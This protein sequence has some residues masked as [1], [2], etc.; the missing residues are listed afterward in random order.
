MRW[1]WLL[2]FSPLW[3]EPTSVESEA[4]HYDG[5]TIT[6][7]GHVHVQNE[8]GELF[9]EKAILTKDEE[10]RT[11]VDFPWIELVHSVH[12]LLKKGQQLDCSRAWL[13]YT[14]KTSLI[15]GDPQLHF[16]DEHGEVF[17]NSGIIDY[18]EDGKK[19]KPTKVTLVGDVKMV[20]EEKGQYALADTVEYFPDD[21]FMILKADPQKRVLFYD[22]KRSVELAAKE[23][24]AKR[25]E[26][27][28]E[29]VQG[30]G[31][32]RFL[33]GAEELDK[34]QKNFRW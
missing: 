7:K 3:A 14:K 32:V 18:V 34:L 29:S 11:S 5:S 28:R 13:D 10:K 27:K 22:K 24:H 12:F 19:L 20:N 26:E 16:F 23:V 9:A 6:L 17:A 21:E 31:N 33:F 25:D 1:L 8:M 30:I 4:A 2:L 15:Q